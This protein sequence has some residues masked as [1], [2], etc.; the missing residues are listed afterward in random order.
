MR[1]IDSR[2]IEE[3]PSLLSVHEA[4]RSSRVFNRV[5]IARLSRRVVVISRARPPRALPA[6]DAR[7]EFT[8]FDL[9]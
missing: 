9:N 4:T 3:H 6:F 2:S 7:Q 5:I 1:G 8:A